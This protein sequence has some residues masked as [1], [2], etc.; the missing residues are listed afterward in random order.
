MFFALN[1]FLWFIVSR[2]DGFVALIEL[3]ES[4]TEC[5]SCAQIETFVVKKHI[6]SLTVVEFEIHNIFFL[7]A[8]S[9]L[10]SWAL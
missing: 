3:Y 7:R 9:H 6:Y 10:R 5:A 1:N 4:T 2:I 8:I